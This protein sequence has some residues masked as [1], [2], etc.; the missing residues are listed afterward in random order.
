MLNAALS[1]DGRTQIALKEE[2]GY[3]EA[4]LYI[5]RE[6]LGQGFQVHKQIDSSLLEQMIPRLIL[7]PIVENAVEHDITARRGGELWVRVYRREDR[8]FLEVEH[9]GRLT[10]ADRKSIGLLLSGSAEGGSQV[11]L[12]NVHQR[13]KLIYG[14]EG[15][16]T[17]E[18]TPSE[19]ILARI[20]FPMAV[21]G[22]G[23]L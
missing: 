21:R 6:R 23:N 19:T 17:I 11:G 3:V 4:Y 7:Q 14:E 9:D 20:C 15:T 22:G 1:R 5:I 2:L 18:E 8:I 13:L 16:L 12:R 10:E